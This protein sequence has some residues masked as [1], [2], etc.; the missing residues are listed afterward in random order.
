MEPVCSKRF[1]GHVARE[2]VESSH[3]Q[4]R[5][6]GDVGDY[7]K[8][9]LLRRLC[10]PNFRLGIVWYTTTIPENNADGKHVNFSHLRHLDEEVFDRLSEFA[11]ERANDQ[12]S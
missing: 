2:S 9:A 4:D 10:K 8:L 3:M 5:Y 11:L 1:S 7:G 12:G 6:A